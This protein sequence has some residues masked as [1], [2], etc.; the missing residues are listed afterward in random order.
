[1]GVKLSL[2]LKYAI[3]TIISFLIIGAV[4][5]FFIEGFL[6]GFIINADLARISQDI[7]KQANK[8]LDLEHS[9]SLKID[10]KYENF[11]K[12]L[13]E[14]E[15]LENIRLADANGQLVYSYRKN[16][17]N[18]SLLELADVKT[19]LNGN[20]SISKID[21][22][23]AT[24]EITVPVKSTKGGVRGIVVAEASLSA[25]LK[26]VN[27]TVNKMAIIGAAA[28][29]IFVM[30]LYFVF[31]DAESTL[32]QKQNSIMDKSKALEEE[33]QLD[34]AIMASVTESLVVINSHGQIMLF[35]K[36]AEKITGLKSSDVE[37][38]LYRKII[39]LVTKDG[40]EISPNPITAALHNGKIIKKNIADGL[41]LKNSKKE[42]IPISIGLAPIFE[43]DNSI[44]GVV[45]TI[46]DI[47][48]EKELDKVKDEFVY[49]V[50]HELGNP[51]FAL[52]GYLSILEDQLK[53]TAKKNKEII[54]SAKNVNSQLST[55]VNDLLEAVRNENGQLSF[56]LEPV[57]I[58]A[59][60]NEVV[61]S[62]KF[63]AKNK[64]ITISYGASKQPKL[65]GSPAKIKEVVTN[66]VDNAIKYTP[67]GGHIDVWHDRDGDFI[68]THVKDNGYGMNQEEQKKL[69]EKFYRIKNEN[70]KGI[71][72][73]GL[74]LFICRQIIEKCGGKVSAESEEGKGSTFSFELKI[75]KK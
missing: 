63:K 20:N 34:E 58:V 46:S 27:A 32:A 67:E 9:T 55:L 74:G 21:Y 6:K 50:A 51:I 49:V 10:N 47:S 66:F 24:G 72:G 59:I 36:E 33:Q 8:T 44:R 13:S 39:P 70:T 73:T 52:D 19:A 29:F 2:R 4:A 35:N 75:A 62:A 12:N 23:N 26:E 22:Q 60:V 3:V 25:N 71:S 45:A 65:T 57:D 31:S 38:R 5:F 54:T 30:V 41:Y 28:S 16:D 53:N 15:K 68:A 14:E 17:E 1:M 40:K 61:D 7:Q 56:E 37:Y 43:K 42:L 18:S 69:F 11:I 48:T 64:N